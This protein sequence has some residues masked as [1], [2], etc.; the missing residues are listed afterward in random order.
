MNILNELRQKRGQIVDQMK[1]LID[2]HPGDK[3]TD[4][5][6]QKYNAMDADQSSL[7]DQIGRV[8][9]QNSLDKELGG[10]ADKIANTGIK[11]ENNATGVA[12]AEYKA[13]FEKA[14]RV[15][16]NNIGPDFMNALQVGTASEGGNIV[17]TDLDSQLVE[18]L[19]DHNEFRNYVTVI[20]TS[21]DR[22]I[23]IEST[24][25]SATW[26]AE[27]AA[28]TESDAAFGK[29]TL[30][31]H[32]LSTIIKVSEELVM[33]SIFDLM[34]YLARNFAKRFANA[35][36]TAFVAGTNSGQPNGFNTAATTGKTTASGTAITADELIDLYHSLS[37]PY[38]RNAAFVLNDS[39][40]ATIRKLK[41]SNNQYLWQP[42]LAAGQPDML[43]GKPVIASDA[44]PAIA[45]NNDTVSF[46]DLSYY[47]VTERG[48]RQ[49]QILNEL[50]AANGQ[51]GYRGF[52]R[53]DGDLIDT[54]AVKN[55]TQ[56]AV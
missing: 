33:D 46:G 31:A 20:Q 41:D 9:K 51:I 28:Y 50:Y 1:N 3:W 30:S 39:T 44:M 34:G 2:D 29:S 15:G 17:P 22:D 10:I 13:A 49:M 42:G 32:K 18:Y 14:M 40:L 24:L 53:L 4:E 36:E 6:E 19:Q 5:I 12:S 25:G 43:L 7:K 56:A 45:V 21:A 23:P 27:E 48:P 26:T 38:R 55:L 35:E 52:E 54:N 37:R 11:P 8:E 16:K 47:Y